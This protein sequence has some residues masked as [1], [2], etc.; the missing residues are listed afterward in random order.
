MEFCDECGA[1]LFPQSD[2]KS[3]KVMLICK[4][5]GNK[6]P[7]PTVDISEYT[8]NSNLANVN[9][10]KI[11]VLK[12]KPTKHKRVTKEDREAYEEFFED[13]N[14]SSSEESGGSED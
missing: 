3:G 12:T 9:R 10:D 2:K 7:Q 14:E 1:L 8:I 4:K 11:P 13:E 6:V 5:C